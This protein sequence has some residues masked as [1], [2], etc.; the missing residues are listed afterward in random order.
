MSA[1]MQGM[2]FLYTGAYER[3]TR[4]LTKAHPI[5]PENTRGVP[6]YHASRN[7]GL[8]KLEMFA[9]QKM[10]QLDEEMPIPEI[11]QVTRDLFFA[12]PQVKHGFQAISKGTCSDY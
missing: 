6:V 1:R 5:S 3:S 10:E 7:H 4:L 11:L 9:K 8:P 2:H 12:F